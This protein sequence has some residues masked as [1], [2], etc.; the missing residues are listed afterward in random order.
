MNELD[1]EEVLDV[2]DYEGITY[3]VCFESGL[4]YFKEADDKHAKHEDVLG[5]L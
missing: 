2:V 4:I 5:L 1:N 3:N